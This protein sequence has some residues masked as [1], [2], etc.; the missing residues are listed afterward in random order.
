MEIP[1]LTDMECPGIT[2]CRCFPQLKNR[3]K[4]KLMV[5]F[6]SISIRKGI[7]KKLPI[8]RKRPSRS[9]RSGRSFGFTKKL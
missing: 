4:H 8:L 1:C 5:I 6:Y 7:E 2:E 3:N 9:D